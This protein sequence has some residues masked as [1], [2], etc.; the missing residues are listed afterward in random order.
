MAATDR[1]APDPWARMHRV[2]DAL[3]P[4]LVAAL[5]TLFARAQADVPEATIAEAIALGRMT[6]ALEAALRASRLAVA[7]RDEL[8]AVVRVVFDGS[9]FTA[10]R[11]MDQ[12]FRLEMDIVNPRAPE[13]AVDHA[14]R[15]VREVDDAMRGALAEMVAAAI[16]EG[17]APRALAREVRRRIGLTTRMSRQVDAFRARLVA[18]GATPTT[19]DASARLLTERLLRRRALTIARTET[20]R[21]GR[22]GRHA[23]WEEARRQGFLPAD[24]KVKWM[25]GRD[26][27]VCPACGPLHGVEVVL[28]GTWETA[29]GPVD[30]PPLHPN[31]RCGT[32]LALRRPG[33]PAPAPPL[34]VAPPPEDSRKDSAR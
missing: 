26:E 17:R 21:A 12:A 6:P 2:P 8:V 10:I 31:C 24:V 9:Y 20:I 16:R 18:Q 14:A 34:P 13:A 4:R 3:R 28:G 15:F 25:T 7:A 30:G 1:A 29:L 11:D 5:R 23:A 32:A 33:A 22:V 19:A 27:R